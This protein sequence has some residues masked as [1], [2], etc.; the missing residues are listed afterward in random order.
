VGY[1]FVGD[2]ANVIRIE[3]LRSTPL[4][5]SGSTKAIPELVRTLILQAIRSTGWSLVFW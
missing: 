5:V 4:I 1:T 2:V 3:T